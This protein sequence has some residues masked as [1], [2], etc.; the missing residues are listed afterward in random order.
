MASLYFLIIPFVVFYNICHCCA[1]KRAFLCLPLIPVIP[2]F[3]HSGSLTPD[4]AQLWDRWL[5][6]ALLLKESHVLG[7]E[8][9][10]ELFTPL[11]LE[12]DA[13]YSHQVALEAHILLQATHIGHRLQPQ[14]IRQLFL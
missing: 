9:L 12:R 8:R 6:H 11:L 10:A 4:A 7:N 14:S 1:V 13:P 3:P 5:K 2:S